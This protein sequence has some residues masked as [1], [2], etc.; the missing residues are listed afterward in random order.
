[1]PATFAAVSVAVGA[2]ASNKERKKEQT[3]HNNAQRKVLR[4][5]LEIELTTK[6]PAHNILFDSTCELLM[7]DW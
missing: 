4:K 2:S 7:M 5:L 6:F 3:T 1:M